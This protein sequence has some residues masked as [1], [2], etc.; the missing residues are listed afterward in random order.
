MYV[1]TLHNK[2]FGF[3]SRLVRVGFLTIKIIKYQ[4]E[5]YKQSYK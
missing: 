3:I 5:E 1:Q 4:K 2:T